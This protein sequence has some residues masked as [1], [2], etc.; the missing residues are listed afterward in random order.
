MSTATKDAKGWF[1]RIPKTAANMFYAVVGSSC[2]SYL[3][4]KYRTFP[5]HQPFSSH[6]KDDRLCVILSVELFAIP[7]KI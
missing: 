5:T 2:E 3:L 1:S 6:Q 7:T 4:T